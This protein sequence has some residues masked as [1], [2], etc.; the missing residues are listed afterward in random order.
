VSETPPL[1]SGA[2]PIAKKVA[3]LTDGE[4]HR[5]HPASPLLRGGIALIA[6]LGAVIANL[7][8]RLLSIFI[9]RFDEGGDPIDYVID[10]GLIIM[11]LHVHKDQ[12]AG[13]RHRVNGLPLRD[14]G[15]LGQVVIP[16]PS[17][18]R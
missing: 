10:N 17:Q 18:E 3:A 2:V 16:N 13:G 5:L 9:P 11:S 8:E 15:G 14:S 7:R 6:V 4:W 12:P 1:A